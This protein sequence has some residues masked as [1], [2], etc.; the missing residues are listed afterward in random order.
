MQTTED[1][2]KIKL[3]NFILFVSKNLGEKNELFKQIK[4]LEGNPQKLIFYAEQLSK[5]SEKK[6]DKFFI[7]DKNYDKLIEQI[8]ADQETK[9]I[10][11]ELKNKEEVLKT[12][13]RYL[14]MFLNVIV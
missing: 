10:Y 4:S 1:F 5:F 14:E 11:D 13:K 12:I 9:K 3:S 7:P 6:E 2:L 8:L